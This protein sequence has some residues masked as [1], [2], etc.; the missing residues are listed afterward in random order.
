MPRYCLRQQ[1]D[2]ELLADYRERH[3]RVWP[4]MLRALAESGWERYSLFLAQDGL[5][6]AYVES[7]DL[8]AAL[9]AMQGTSANQRWQ[10]EMARFFV[11]PG[12]A[13]DLGFVLMEEIFDLDD[14]LAACPTRV[15][16]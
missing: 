4:E 8:D 7:P 6:I 5:V 13:P 3:A 11:A 16:S 9:A 10:A 12:G 15:E 1:V 14:Q 2:P